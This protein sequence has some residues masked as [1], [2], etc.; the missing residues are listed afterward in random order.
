MTNTWNEAAQYIGGLQ[1]TLAGNRGGTIDQQ[2]KLAQAL[3]TLSVAQELAFLRMS[4]EK[5]NA[6]GQSAGTS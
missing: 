1:Q 5:G 3:A 4:N 6:A 2:L